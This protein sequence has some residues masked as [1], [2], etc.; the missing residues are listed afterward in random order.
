TYSGNFLFGGLTAILS[1]PCTAPLFPGLL[2]WAAAQNSKWIG[3]FMLTMVGV[4]MAAPYLVLSAVPELARKFPR[5]GPWSE[6]VK[7]MLG[8][9]VLAVAVFIAGQRVLAGR[10]FWGVFAVLLGRESFFT[11]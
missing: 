2:A 1:T 7:Q 10:Q 3:V 4:G 5:T 6:V 8:F 9:M 11:C